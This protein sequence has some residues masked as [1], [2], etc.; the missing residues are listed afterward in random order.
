MAHQIRAFEPAHAGTVVGDASA[1]AGVVDGYVLGR[2]PRD[3]RTHD[4]GPRVTCAALERTEPPVGNDAV[5]VEEDDVLPADATQGQ[6]AFL[7]GVQQRVT[8]Q[9]RDVV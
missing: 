3:H 9:Q 8:V 1:T 4:V 6:I 7:V 2:A 5:V